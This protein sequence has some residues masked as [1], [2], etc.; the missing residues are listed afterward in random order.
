[1]QKH[2]GKI[3]AAIGV[4]F[5]LSYFVAVYWSIEPTVFNV[6]EKAKARKMPLQRLVS[7]KRFANN[8]AKLK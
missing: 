6:V 1:M 4:L 5:V 8:T 2:L 3:S 7:K